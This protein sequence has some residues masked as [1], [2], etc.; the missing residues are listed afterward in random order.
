[1]LLIHSANP[2]SRPIGIIVFAHVVR[3]SVRP[4]VP[5]F[6]NLAKLNKVKTMFPTGDTVG[7]AEWVIDDT[8]LVFVVFPSE[9]LK[10]I[11]LRQLQ[12]LMTTSARKI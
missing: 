12:E 4:S 7:L 6:Q 2:Q 9:M 1:M 5:T 10:Y 8:C 11:L 3:L